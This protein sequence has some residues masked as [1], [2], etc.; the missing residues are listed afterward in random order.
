MS[1][2]IAL[3]DGHGDNG[4]TAGKR[5]P[6]F[7]NGEIDKATGRNMMYEN[8]FNKNVIKYLDE[9]LKRHGFR[10]L[11]VAPTDADTPLETR[12]NLANKNKADLYVSV[13][14]NA[15]AG[16][17]GS[18]GG[19]ET[20]TW[21]SG[22][23]LRIG[24]LIHAELIKGTP[25]RDRGVKNGSHLWEIRATNMPAV[26]VECGFMDSLTDYKYLLSDAYRKECAIEIC[27]GICKAYNVTYKEEQKEVVK[28]VLGETIKGVETDMKLELIDSQWRQLATIFR[29][30]VADGVLEDAKWE[31]KALDKT[32]TLSEL[33]FLSILLDHRRFRDY[34]KNKK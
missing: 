15:S 20:L 14:A 21:G 12:T 19:I 2:L 31:K 7:P 23:S 11:L 32:L 33:A 10:T 18:H 34:V 28:E 29:E 22:E 8:T 24:K 16:K 4:V 6:I 9:E 3:S 13:H 1:K 17:W 27:K 25:L 5:T 26:L 30:A